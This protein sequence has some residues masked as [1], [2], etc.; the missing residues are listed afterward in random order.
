MLNSL[1]KGAIC[2]KQRAV[3]LFRINLA[4]TQL[5]QATKSSSSHHLAVIS[6]D[7]LINQL[8]R[9]VKSAFFNLPI[10]AVFST[11]HFANH[12]HP[13]SSIYAVSDFINVIVLPLMPPLFFTPC[14]VFCC[15]CLS[16]FARGLIY[17]AT[18]RNKIYI[19]LTV[20][21]PTVIRISGTRCLSVRLAA[22]QLF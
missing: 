14:R 8:A 13:N 20:V 22:Q 18:I 19:I 1:L 11:N 15:L 6:C 3:L 16:I 2:R 9:L 21:A 10:L 7:Q 12:F 17:P 4:Q 5:R